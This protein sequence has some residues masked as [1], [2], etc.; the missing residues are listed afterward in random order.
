MDY[1][2]ERLAEYGPETYGTLK[3]LK[4]G[5]GLV[6]KLPAKLKPKYFSEVIMRFDSLLW[7]KL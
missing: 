5:F 2:E 6:R 4:N 3:E 7:S 1:I